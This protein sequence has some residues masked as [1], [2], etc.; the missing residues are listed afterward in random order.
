MSKKPKRASGA[1]ASTRALAQVRVSGGNQASQL[2]KL[3]PDD[4]VQDQP[5]WNQHCRSK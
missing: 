2:T 4:R 1:S 5:K 3:G